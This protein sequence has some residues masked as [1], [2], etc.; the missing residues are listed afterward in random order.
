MK[1][2]LHSLTMLALMPLG[3]AA[4][5]AYDVALFGDMPY[6][7]AREPAYE[8]L[9]AD[10]NDYHPRFGVHIGDTKSG[11]TLLRGFAGVQDSK[12]FQQIPHAG[13]LFGGGQ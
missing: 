5:N 7:T 3:L 12:L 1:T 9:I 10:V 13:D 2:T 11:S 8:R 4:Q 6:G